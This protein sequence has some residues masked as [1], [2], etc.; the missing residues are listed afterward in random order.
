M[1]ITLKMFEFEYIFTD[2][3]ITNLLAYLEKLL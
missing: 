1:T 2:F 3:Y